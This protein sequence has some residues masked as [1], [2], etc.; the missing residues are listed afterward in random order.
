MNKVNLGPLFRA[1]NPTYTLDL[2]KESDRRYY[3]DFTAVR[4]N[5]IIRELQRT[6]VLSGDE[7]TCQLF[8]GHIG[9]GKS[10]ELSELKTKLEQDG[11]HVVYFRSSQDL[12]PADVDISDILLAIARQVSHSLEEAGIRLQP[13]RFQELLQDTVNLLNSDVTGLN[14][15]IPKGGN[16]GVKT[17]KG[18]STLSL[19]IAEITT[20]ARNSNTIRTFLRQH[21]EPRV[22]NILEALNQELIIPAQQ[23]L[24]AAN[25]AGLVVIVD[26]LDRIDNKTRS[27]ETSQ[28][29]YLFVERGEQLKRLQCHL[30]YTIPLVLN[31]SNEKENLVNRFGVDPKL[32]PMVRVQERDGSICEQGLVLLRQ[33]ILARA[34]PLV[35]SE[36]RLNLISELFDSPQTLDRLC[37]ISGGHVRNLLVLC[38]KCLQIEDPPITR[39]LLEKVITQ[40]RTE[41]TRAITPDEW[42]L[43]KKVKDQQAVNGEEEYQTLLKSL[44]V[45]EYW[46]DVGGWFVINPLLD[47]G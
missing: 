29:E 32:L 23:Q 22:N 47:N 46:D 3:I 21:L 43:L 27:G 44:F 6:I 16:W 19:G 11:F 42:E 41:L 4:G 10:T 31:F 9:C 17:D 2:S 1:C 45:F 18:K 35:E 36:Q 34:F 39:Q 28:P 25:Q 5:N 30:V 12:D 37:T 13:N 33:M 40:R 26:D 15:K 7:P 8:T 38:Y 24:K 14:L 20:K